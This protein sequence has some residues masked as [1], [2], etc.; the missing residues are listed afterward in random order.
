MLMLMHVAGWHGFTIKTEVV[1]CVR[2]LSENAINAFLVFAYK[3]YCVIKRKVSTPEN[4]HI[5]MV[6]TV[7]IV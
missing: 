6:N 4:Q 5:C 1:D 3:F 2:I 7:C